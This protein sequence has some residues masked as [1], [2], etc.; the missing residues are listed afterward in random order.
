MSLCRRSHANPTQREEN[1]ESLCRYS[2]LLKITWIGLPQ[3]HE[4]LLDRGDAIVLLLF[5]D[6]I[7]LFVVKRGDATRRGNGGL[8][9]LVRWQ[10]CADLHGEALGNL[11]NRFG[12]SFSV[13]Q[14][15]SPPICQRRALVFPHHVSAHP[16]L[17]LLPSP[18]QPRSP[19]LSQSAFVSKGGEQEEKK[20]KKQ[21]RRDENRSNLSHLLSPC[22]RC[23]AG[24]SVELAKLNGFMRGAADSDP[25]NL[26]DMQS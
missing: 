15:P 11:H 1:R 9:R 14:W 22:S 17:S 26:V 16:P 3:P 2:N 23:S 10:P 13:V 8:L 18:A 4:Y 19:Y 20:K 7:G 24:I 5:C 25:S 21:K 12:I 6:W